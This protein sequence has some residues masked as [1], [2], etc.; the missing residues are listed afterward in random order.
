M[1]CIMS[2]ETTDAVLPKM[3]RFP[4]EVGDPSGK[5]LVDLEFLANREAIRNHI[6]A[7]G[8]VLDDET[9]DEYMK[10]FTEDVIVQ[11]SGSGPG[12]GRAGRVSRAGFA[13]RVGPS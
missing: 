3:K 2:K 9:F 8:H 4:K 6:A 5:V 10:L 12:P 7:Y 11:T 13:G 1:E